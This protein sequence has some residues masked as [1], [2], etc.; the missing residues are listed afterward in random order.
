MDVRDFCKAVGGKVVN[1][2]KCRLGDIVFEVE[3]D[4]LKIGFRGKPS[5]EARVDRVTVQKTP[6]LNIVF[7]KL[8]P[9]YPRNKFTGEVLE[10]L[11]VASSDKT[12][13]FLVADEKKLTY[14]DP[15]ALTGE[16]K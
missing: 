13:F 6:L 14:V 10:T 9:P 16:Y 12:Y 7:F 3:G 15:S 8:K 11:A 4:K 2:S 5:L 1:D